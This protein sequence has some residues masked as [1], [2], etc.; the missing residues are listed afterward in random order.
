MIAKQIAG[1]QPMSSGAGA[2]FNMGGELEWSMWQRTFSLWPRRSITNKFIFGWINKSSL[3]DWNVRIG[4]GQTTM[5]LPKHMQAGR[6]PKR[7]SR[8]AT[9]KELFMTKLKGET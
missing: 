8:F 4:P 9:D 2:L 6:R 3:D 7:I 1:V 5:S